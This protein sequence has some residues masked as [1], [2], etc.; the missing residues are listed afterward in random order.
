MNLYDKKS[1]SLIKSRFEAGHHQALLF[2]HQY[3]KKKIGGG[4]LLG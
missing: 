4:F 3:F 1:L 2:Y